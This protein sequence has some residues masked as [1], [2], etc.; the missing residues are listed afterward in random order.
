MHPQNS[1]LR[2]FIFPSLYNAHPQPLP[3][4]RGLPLKAVPQPQALSLPASHT[5]LESFAC[6]PQYLPSNVLS[7]LPLENP[8]T[9]GNP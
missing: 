1:L 4:P 2:M 8:F 5:F 7:S 3:P 9:F 6:E